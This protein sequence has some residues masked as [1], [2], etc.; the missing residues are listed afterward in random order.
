MQLYVYV[1]RPI[2]VA[3]LLYIAQSQFVSIRSAIEI[4]VTVLIVVYCRANALHFWAFYYWGRPV[5]ADVTTF[6]PTACNK[7]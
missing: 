2:Y 3:W 6:L 1:C 7:L 5:L 4:G